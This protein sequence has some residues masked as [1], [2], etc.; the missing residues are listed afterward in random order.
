M[1]RF[2][3]VETRR[4]RKVNVHELRTRRMCAITITNERATRKMYAL[5]INRLLAE[6]RRKSLPRTRHLS[7]DYQF[8]PLSRPLWMQPRRVRIVGALAATVSVLLVY[9]FL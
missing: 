2:T 7:C 8:A 3:H 5:E 6:E 4:L 9:W 1:L